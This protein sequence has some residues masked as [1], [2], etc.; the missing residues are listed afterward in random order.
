[1]NFYKVI[2][3]IILLELSQ[4]AINKRK[5]GSLYFERESERVS[6]LH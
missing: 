5:S 4:A 6:E 2:G 1:M 3:I